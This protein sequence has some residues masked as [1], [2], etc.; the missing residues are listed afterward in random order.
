[1]VARIVTPVIPAD[2]EAA[3]A[4]TTPENQEVL[5]SRVKV[6]PAAQTTVAV[7]LLPA[8][9]AAQVDKETK[10]VVATTATAAEDLEARV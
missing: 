1:M 4:A 3:P 9:A 2:P 8:E 5:E 7:G 10:A 6:I